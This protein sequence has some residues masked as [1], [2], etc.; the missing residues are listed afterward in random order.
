MENF[1]GQTINGFELQAI[2]GKGSFGAVYKAIQ[3]TSSKTEWY[4]KF[5]IL[6]FYTL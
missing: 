4:I 5:L 2:L 6:E 1:T 3:C